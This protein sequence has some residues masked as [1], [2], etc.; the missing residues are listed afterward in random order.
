MSEYRVC[1]VMVNGHKCGNP[2]TISI[3]AARRGNRPA[4]VCAECA[5]RMESYS[6]ENNME[7]GISTRGKTY[8]MELETN[9]PTTK[10][11]YDLSQNLFMPTSDI[12]VGLEFK[13]VIYNN[14]KSPVRVTKTIERLINSGDIEIG[15]NCGTHFHV[16][17]PD[18]GFS[19]EM[20]CGVSRRAATINMYHSLFLP[21]SDWLREHPAET[22]A[23]FGRNFGEWARPISRST[24]TQEHENFINLQHSYSIEF[25]LCFFKSAAQYALCMKTC[26]KIWDALETHFWSN[27]TAERS[28]SGRAARKAAAKKAARYIVR[29]VEKASAEAMN[30]R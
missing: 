9:N 18:N 8:S 28:E 24:D 7:K 2:A 16:G 1:S 11:R 26:D 13:S 6:R 3:P 27:Y 22:A 21:L 20:P 14:L 19:T 5:A 17:L 25:R 29:I 4:C 23:L 10:A 12:T 15:T 30:I